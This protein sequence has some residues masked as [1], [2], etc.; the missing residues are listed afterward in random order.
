MSTLHV[1]TGYTLLLLGLL[2]V[3]CESPT[4]PSSLLPAT[5]ASK[6]ILP[7]ERQFQDS[8]WRQIAFRGVEDPGGVNWRTTR[9]FS[10]ASPNLYIR[11]DDP[12]GRRVVSYGHRDHMRR[13]FP[14]LVE[15]LTG[16]S[17]RGRVEDGFGDRSRVGWISLQ[18]STESEV[19]DAKDACGAAF[20]GADPGQIWIYRRHRN[21]SK[22][23]TENS[24]VF[25]EVFAHEVGHAVGLF[26][27]NDRNAVMHPSAGGGSFTGREVYHAKLLYRFSGPTRYSSWPF[28]ASC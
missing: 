4:A 12:T 18:F 6:T 22:S 1:R 23:C 2:A 3:A 27:V 14:R 25:A 7:V 19:P 8:F 21:G 26:H 17:Y 10:T 28:G 13:T 5:T 15:Q 24:R 16:K 11:M 20:V 9:P